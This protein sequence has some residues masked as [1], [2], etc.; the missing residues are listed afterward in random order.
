MLDI[1][2]VICS[3][4]TKAHQLCWTCGLQLW[5]CGSDA[6]QNE[7]LIGKVEPW[8]LVIGIIVIPGAS[9]TRRAERKGSSSELWY[10]LASVDRI[11]A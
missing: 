1:A 5:C 2:D 3:A 7:S 9:G 10:L 11:L 4:T 8:R 6:T